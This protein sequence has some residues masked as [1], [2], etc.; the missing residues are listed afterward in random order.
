MPPMPRQRV[1][2]PR[3]RGQ[4]GKRTPE[5]VLAHRAALARSL[6]EDPGAGGQVAPGHARS[7]SGPHVRTTAPARGARPARPRGLTA[8]G[9]T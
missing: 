5:Q 6:R 2:S 9:L 8:G 7:P 3:P 1:K 4:A